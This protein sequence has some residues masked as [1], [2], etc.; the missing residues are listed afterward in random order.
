MRILVQKS[1]S[2]I[3]SAFHRPSRKATLLFY[4]PSIAIVSVLILRLVQKC[5]LQNEALA[6]PKLCEPRINLHFCGDD[7]SLQPSYPLEL[8]TESKQEDYNQDGAVLATAAT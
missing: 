8:S 2:V 4:S 6:E 7:T 1:I 5:D 3:A